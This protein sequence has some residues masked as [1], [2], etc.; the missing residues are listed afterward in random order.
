[1][2]R[3][4]FEIDIQGLDTGVLRNMAFTEGIGDAIELSR[5][6][7]EA[8]GTDHTIYFTNLEAERQPN[9][10]IFNMKDVNRLMV[11]VIDDKGNKVFHRNMKKKVEIPDDKNK[12]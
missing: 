8:L 10:T 3:I 1:M 9:I 11:D 2:Y 7:I 12:L 4:E 5:R 6:Y